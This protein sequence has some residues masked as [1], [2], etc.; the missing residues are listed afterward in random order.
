MATRIPQTVPTTGVAATAHAASGGG[1]KVP[2]DSIIRAINGSGGSINLTMVTPQ[3]LD[4]NLAV[5]DRV[6][7]VPAGQQRYVRATAFY[8]NATDG[9]VD[10]TWSAT[11]DVTFEVIK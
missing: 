9:L 3:V 2:P 5:P 10:I 6:V 8:R 1:D 11:S 4:G 7:A